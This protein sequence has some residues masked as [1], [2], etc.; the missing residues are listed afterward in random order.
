MTERRVFLFTE[1][2]EEEKLLLLRVPLPE[3]TEEEEEEEEVQTFYFVNF[4]RA[5]R[6]ARANAHAPSSFSPVE[7]WTD[8]DVTG[9]GSA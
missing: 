2:E 7:Q 4:L 8:C 5:P 1:E 3:T 6:S 9:G